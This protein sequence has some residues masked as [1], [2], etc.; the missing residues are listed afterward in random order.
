MKDSRGRLRAILAASLSLL[1]ILAFHPE[2]LSA[3]STEPVPL[4]DL[5]APTTAPVNPNEIPRRTTAPQPVLAGPVDPKAYR[6]G[7]GDV[8]SIEYGG[9]AE[10]ST[11]LVVDSEGR[12]RVPNLGVVSV[13]HMTLDE[14][15]AAIFK[16][17]GPLLPRATLDLRLLEPRTFK[18]FVL[19][20]VRNAGVEQVTGSARVSEAIEAAGGADSNG[21]QRNVRVLR[22]DGSERAADLERFLRTGDWEANP[23]LEDGDRVV[24][25]PMVGHIFVYGSVPLPGA[26]EFRTG[27]SLMTA[28]RLAGGL[29]PE[30]LHDSVLVV[31]FHSAAGTDSLITQLQDPE[32]AT[33]GG[34]PLREDDRIFIRSQPQWHRKQNVTISG[35]VVYPGV[36]P[37]R[38]GTDRIT[39]LLKDAGGFTEFAARSNIHLERPLLTAEPD[40]E[41]ERL[42]RLSRD[43]MT[44]TE[45]QTFRSKL[46]RRQSIYVVDFS[47]GALPASSDILL[48][49]GDRIDVGRLELSVRVDGSVV[50]P[51]LVAYEQGR[52]YLDYIKLAGGPSRRGEWGDARVTRAGTGNTVFARDLKIIEPG[53][54]IFVPEKK[55]VSFWGVFKDVIVV[56]GQVATIVIV[57]DQ[58]ARR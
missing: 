29:L 23:Y 42:S 34:I 39:T 35:E 45:Y 12:V 4:P 57:V 50:R 6:L 33:D 55:D 8:L 2:R 22:S 9:R 1:A 20:E 49:D 40:P 19:G 53:D 24:V 16:R 44:N 47:H 56:A 14:A 46:A 43:Q 31:R 18:V 11:T 25:P 52:S 41:F 15:R 48:Q 58:F 21:S 36:Y 37:I 17:L 26:H 5:G 30:A 10:G 3:Q 38:P 7:P 32:R 51:G 54:F 13:S 27:D 28:V